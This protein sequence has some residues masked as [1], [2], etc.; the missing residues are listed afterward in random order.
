MV[1]V[2]NVLRPISAEATICARPR[3]Q[4]AAIA[5]AKERDEPLMFKGDDFAGTDIPFVGDR[6]AR[7]RLAELVA[8]Y[9]A[10]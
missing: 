9:G 8:T 3:Q 2:G 5:L 6:R 1:E 4:S 10:T 7:H